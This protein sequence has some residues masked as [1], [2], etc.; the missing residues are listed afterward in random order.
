MM[1]YLHTYLSNPLPSIHIMVILCYDVDISDE[2]TP[3]QQ[4]PFEPECNTFLRVFFLPYAMN[5]SIDGV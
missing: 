2:E 5:T 3:M 1:A 4:T